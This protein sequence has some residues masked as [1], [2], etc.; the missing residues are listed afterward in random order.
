MH[1][2]A[3]AKRFSGY[4]RVLRQYWKL[5]YRDAGIIFLARN[6]DG[7]V[8]VGSFPERES[9][10]TGLVR[11]KRLR[12]LATVPPRDLQRYPK[13]ERLFAQPSLF[14]DREEITQ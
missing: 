14:T 5:G 13:L 11:A 8:S 9:D 3:R 2:T 6:K 10:M 4:A 12:Y 7:S 1:R